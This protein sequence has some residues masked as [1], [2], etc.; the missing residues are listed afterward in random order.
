[1]P[2]TADKQPD[3]GRIVRARRE[4]LGLGL[5]DLCDLVSQQSTKWGRVNLD[6]TTLWE[7]EARGVVP[8]PPRRR[9]IAAVLDCEQGDIWEFPGARLAALMIPR[10][11]NAR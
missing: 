1:M 3:A 2:R 4:A 6:R 11:R 7:I 5:Q 10:E 8:L 9:A